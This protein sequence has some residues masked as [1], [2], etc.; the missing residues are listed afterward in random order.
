M[1]DNEILAKDYFTYGEHFSLDPFE[2]MRSYSCEKAL[3]KKELRSTAKLIHQQTA[4]QGLAYKAEV[5]SKR[6]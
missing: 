6:K 1:H 3:C 4:E 2:T 5:F